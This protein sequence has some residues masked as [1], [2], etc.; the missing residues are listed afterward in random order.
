MRTIN[1]IDLVKNGGDGL[2]EPK[3]I[4]MFSGGKDST[5]LLW[6]CLKNKIPVDRILFCDST[7]EYPPVY[8]WLEHIEERLNVEILK[9]IPKSS[10]YELIMRIRKR[11]KFKGKIRGFPG[12][13]CYCWVNRDL[14]FVNSTDRVWLNATRLIAICADEFQRVSRVDPKV[15]KHP[16]RWPLIEAEI[17]ERQVIKEL[18]ELDL[19]PPVYELLEKYGAKS[20]RTG[21]WIC[22]YTNYPTLKMIYY[23]WPEM[24]ECLKYWESIA[25]LT[26]KINTTVKEIEA[27]IK[28][29]EHQTKLTEYIR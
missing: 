2:P 8:D 1:A 23:E 20:P 6:Y 15:F 27:K 9:V 18:K 5:Y 14:K 4:L 16:I 29:D 24:W 25:P 22:P 12:I 19:Y 28:W 26:W 3:T 11:G 21:C 7:V 13:A 17:T 10:F